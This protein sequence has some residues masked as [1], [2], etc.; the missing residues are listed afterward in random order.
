MD[1]TLQ[2]HALL[3][4]FE[5]HATGTTVTAPIMPQLP[6]QRPR[7]ADACPHGSSTRTERRGAVPER[8][9]RLPAP[10]SEQETISV[11]VAT[12][13]AHTKLLCTARCHTPSTCESLQL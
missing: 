13:S 12:C 11:I 7:A 8:A 2:V 4:G 9:A 3:S 6:R 1:T 10:C 5:I